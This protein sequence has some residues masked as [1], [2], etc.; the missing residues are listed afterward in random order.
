MK[1]RRR[2]QEDKRTFQVEFHGW[3]I[4]STTDRLTGKQRKER[5]EGELVLNHSYT[6]GNGR[7]ILVLI[8]LHNNLPRITSKQGIK[9]LFQ[10]EKGVCKTTKNLLSRTLILSKRL[11]RRYFAENIVG[12]EVEEALSIEAWS[13]N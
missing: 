6:R 13:V 2:R 1:S 5:H 4:E 3:I 7:I 8:L 9:D 11:T 12:H 10:N